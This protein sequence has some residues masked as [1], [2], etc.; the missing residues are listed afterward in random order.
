MLN[1]FKTLCLII[2]LGL[3]LQGRVHAREPVQFI[4]LI[5]HENIQ[6]RQFL[7]DLECMLEAIYVLEVTIHDAHALD[8]SS[9][10]VNERAQHKGEHVLNILEHQEDLRALTQKG[11]V[12]Y[13]I[14]QDM[15]EMSYRNGAYLL[16]WMN[17]NIYMNA[18]SLARLRHEDNHTTT[19][20]LFRLVAKNTAKFL[21]HKPSGQCF[22]GY[23]QDIRTLDNREIRLCEPDLSAL[24]K[25]GLIRAD[26][27]DG[28]VMKGC[29][30]LNAHSMILNTL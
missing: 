2:F 29:E 20:R 26:I 4:H 8:F 27:R 23:S 28:T 16:G 6:D 9:L 18:I 30:L 13:F 7:E 15:Y 24:K 25:I 21:G 3:M 10:P 12:F 11:I 1:R 19:N 14:S 17:Y 22:M 5:A